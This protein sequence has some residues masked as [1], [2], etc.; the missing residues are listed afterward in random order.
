MHLLFDLDGTLTDSQSGII[1]SIRHALNEHGL[2]APAADSLRW[3]IG[4]PILKTFAILLGED[5]AHLFDRVIGSYRQ[6]YGEIGL[7]ENQVYPEIEAA[8]I[9]LTGLGHT[10]HVATSKAGIYAGR[11]IEHFGLGRYF[12]S[13]DGSELDGTRADK[14]LLI[15]HILEREGIVPTDAIMIGDREHDMIGTV[16]NGVPGIGV[17]WGYGS[18]EELTSAGAFTC[19]H[20]PRELAETIRRNCLGMSGLEDG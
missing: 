11:I 19:I 15:A 3:V 14:T 6:R 13:I 20:S 1:R 8:L 5:S 16:A 2:A 18:E 4:P 17:L 9:E 12:H 7:F 10:L